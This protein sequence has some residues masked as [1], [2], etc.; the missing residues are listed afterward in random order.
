MS[1]EVMTALHILK[2]HNMKRYLRIFASSAMVFGVALL[3]TVA[4]PIGAGAAS[5]GGF[6][7]Y[8]YNYTARVFNGTYSSWCAHRQW[9]TSDCAAYF[10]G[11]GGSAATVNDQLIMKWNAAWDACNKQ[12]SATTCAGAWEDNEVNGMVPGGDGTVWH[13]KIVYSSSCSIGVASLT[14]GGYCIWNGIGGGYEVI[15]DQGTSNGVHTSNA[16]AIPNGYGSYK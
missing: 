10:E 9:S 7:Q 3:G 2:G 15:M 14:D 16:L 6:D 5:G 13:Y 4:T 12:P 1:I 8:G 11:N